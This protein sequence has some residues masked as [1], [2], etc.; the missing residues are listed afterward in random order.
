MFKVKQDVTCLHESRY[1]QLFERNIVLMANASTLDPLRESHP[2]RASFRGVS[3]SDQRQIALT[4]RTWQYRGRLR[5]VRRSQS[6]EDDQAW[7][8]LECSAVHRRLDRQQHI[9]SI[10]SIGT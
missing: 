3:H 6:C 4:H 5:L 8:S 2:G 1:R 7:R 10:G 9:E